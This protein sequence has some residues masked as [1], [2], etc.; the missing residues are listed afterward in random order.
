[1]LRGYAIAPSSTQITCLEWLF[2]EVSKQLCS[3]SLP[4]LPPASG[5]SFPTHT[6]EHPS[7][8]QV[9]LRDCKA[10]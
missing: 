1:M 7:P 3:V 8:V 9:P 6:K 4:Q 5:A 2:I 10:G